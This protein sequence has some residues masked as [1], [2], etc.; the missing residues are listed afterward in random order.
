MKDSPNPR[1][2]IVAALAMITGSIG[3]L[4][5]LTFWHLPWLTRLNSME[6]TLFLNLAAF[7]ILGLALF[8]RLGKV[9]QR[10]Q[11]SFWNRAEAPTNH[12]EIAFERSLHDLEKS[13]EKLGSIFDEQTKK[14][15]RNSARVLNSVEKVFELNALAG[16][17]QRQSDEISDALGSSAVKLNEL[18]ALASEYAHFA[19]ATRLEWNAMGLKTRD[20]RDVNTKIQDYIAKI[21]E[22]SMHTYKLIGDHQKAESAIVQKIDHIN[23]TQMD[24]TKES[25]DGLARLNHMVQSINTS[26]GSVRDAASLVNGLSERA[27]AIVQIIDAIDDISE[28]TNLLALNASIE[29]ARAGEQGQG[30]AVVAEEVRKLAARSSTATRSIADLLITIQ[31]EA[32]QASDKLAQST[33]AVETATTSVNEVSNSYK[34]A[35]N[36]SRAA[37]IDIAYLE[38]DV[39]SHFKQIS[40]T[41]K[42]SSELRN[43]FK[44][45]NVLLTEQTTMSSK[46][47]SGIN[48]L[49]THSDRIARLIDR[50]HHEIGYC[51]K[52]LENCREM[53]KSLLKSAV[54]LDRVAAEVASSSAGSAHL[55]TG[56]VGHSISTE[57]YKHVQLMKN[58]IQ[59]L[60]IIKKPLDENQGLPKA[61]QDDQKPQELAG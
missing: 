41:L 52:L 32:G 53:L 35:I 38:R 51:F 60:E 24:I 3:I 12:E 44:T 50:Q 22:S 59:T 47:I 45:L 56:I 57:A 46:A 7:L 6:I 11:F 37:I 55:D 4:C 26:L 1:L 17:I 31:D 25:K 54:N 48:N 8:L 42:S 29:A 13:A 28:Q 5:D 27:E 61:S 9:G 20:A 43:F 23:R 18:M 21:Q 2:L 58:A 30:F 16:C 15:F 10:N 14:G 34:N 36:A 49:I 40:T 33:T 39:G 19:D